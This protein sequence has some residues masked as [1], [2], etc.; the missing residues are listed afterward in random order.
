VTVWLK[1]GTTAPQIAV[2]GARLA[3]TSAVSGC[4]Y[5]SQLTD[6]LRAEKLLP[7]AAFDPLMPTTTPASFQCN[8]RQRRQRG[9]LVRTFA[10]L[11]AVLTVTVPDDTISG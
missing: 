11:P 5:R 6:Y 10:G 2:I 1:P 7:K 4:A 8:L 3:R 9:A